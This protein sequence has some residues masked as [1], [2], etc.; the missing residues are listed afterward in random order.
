MKP[1]SDGQSAVEH[2]TESAAESADYEGNDA[3]RNSLLVTAGHIIDMTPMKL[4]D[5]V[6]KISDSVDILCIPI[7][8]LKG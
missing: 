3:T 2:V 6:R 7:R 8:I 1:R 5:R 4:Q